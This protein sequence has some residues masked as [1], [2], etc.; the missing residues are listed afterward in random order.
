MTNSEYVCVLIFFS[1]SIDSFLHPL[2]ISF[3][4]EAFILQEDHVPILD[5][6]HFEIYSLRFEDSSCVHTGRFSP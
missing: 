5:P 6:M 1:T 4:Y 2:L 3:S